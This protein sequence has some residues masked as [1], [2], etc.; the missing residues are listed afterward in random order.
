MLRELSQRERERER[1][2]GRQTD[3]DTDRLMTE[4][5][6]TVDMKGREDNKP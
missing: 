1:E 4:K 5:I 2:G 6:E 3:T